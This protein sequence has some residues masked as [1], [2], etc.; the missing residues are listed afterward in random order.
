MIRAQQKCPRTTKGRADGR[1][2]AVLPWCDAARGSSAPVKWQKDEEGRLFW[3]GSCWFWCL[4]PCNLRG[5]K[6]APGSRKKEKSPRNFPKFS[7]PGK[8]METVHVCAHT[9]RLLQPLVL[10]DPTRGGDPS[11]RVR[12]L[13]WGWDPAGRQ[14]GLG[15]IWLH[16]VNACWDGGSLDFI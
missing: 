8:E 1:G 16:L 12:A 13:D 2:H 4:G 3:L 5:R 11:P 10:Q 7:H 9:L 15:T 6:L 14:L